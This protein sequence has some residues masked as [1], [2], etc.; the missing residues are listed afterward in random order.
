MRKRFGER[1]V[2][3]AFAPKVPFYRRFTAG[4]FGA[5]QAFTG[6][7]NRRTKFAA[8]SGLFTPPC[9][10]RVAARGMGTRAASRCAG[11]L[12]PRSPSR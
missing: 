1:V 4:L 8:C 3:A 12:C 2:E 11:P 5:R 7:S 9:G 6:A 10:S